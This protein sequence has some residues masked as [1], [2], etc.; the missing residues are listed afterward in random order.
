MNEEAVR[1][2]DV[3]NKIIDTIKIKVIDALYRISFFI[4]YLIT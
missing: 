4:G 3:I 1:G 2:P